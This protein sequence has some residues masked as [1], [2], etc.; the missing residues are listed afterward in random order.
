MPLNFETY[1]ILFL[2]YTTQDR[3]T[4]VS[5]INSFRSTNGIIS[6]LAVPLLWYG[7]SAKTLCGRSGCYVANGASPPSS[8]SIGSPLAPESMPQFDHPK[9]RHTFASW[10]M[11]NGGDLYELAKILGHSNIRMTERSAKLGRRHIA[12]TGNTAREIWKLL[13]SANE[14]AMFAHSSHG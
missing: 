2:S 12:R 6:S 4:S 3:L 9:W 8:I 10:Y 13:E 7:L 14:N 1:Y 5:T 11:M